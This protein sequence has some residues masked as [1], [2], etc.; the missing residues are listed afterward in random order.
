MDLK[1]PKA[2]RGYLVLNK[3][4]VM[5]S[6]V[7]TNLFISLSLTPTEPEAIFRVTVSWGGKNV[8]WKQN[9]Y[10]GTQ[11]TSAIYE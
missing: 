11:D 7:C 3:Y 10:L 2:K 9:Q 4:F 5:I 1:I 6:Q 8:V